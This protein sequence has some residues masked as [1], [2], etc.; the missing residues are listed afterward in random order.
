MPLRT[1]FLKILCVMGPSALS[2]GGVPG[3]ALAADPAVTFAPDGT[4]HIVNL[5]V[6]I[7][8]TISPEAQQMLRAGASA[9]DPTQGFTLPVADLRRITGEQFAQITARLLQMYPS[10]VERKSIAGVA[11]ALVTPRT[12]APAA[13]GR[14]LINLH[15]GVFML[16]QGSIVEAVP[17]AALAGIPVLAI[18]YRLAPEHPYPAAVDDTIA[19]YRELLRSYPPEHLALYGTSAGA[20]LTAQ[21]AVRARQLRL[22]LP[23]ALGFFSGTA[24][25]AR[26]SDTETMFSMP[27]F[28]AAVTP[29]AIQAKAYLA[30]NSLTDP[31]MSPIYADLKG[32]PPTLLMT[33]TRDFFLG[34]TANFHRALLHAGTRAELVV[35]DA[36]PHDHW[37][38]PGM[39]ETDEALSLQ[40]KFLAAE[41]LK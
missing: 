34:S 12:L 31:V 1:S 14:L 13:K 35:F 10:T 5:T 28:A 40:A 15:G 16:G 18:D 33:G 19:V 2:L 17:I 32:F 7:P 22:A 8:Q 11:V 41:V 9:G 36:M 20:V 27:G 23:A 26:Q 21:V 39:P 37:T 24:D 30:N 25:F 38:I 4:V 29:T 6:P 3:A